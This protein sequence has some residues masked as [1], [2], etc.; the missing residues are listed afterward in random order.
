MNIRKT[1]GGLLLS[2]ILFTVVVAA[3]KTNFSG[4][5]VM[6]QAEGIPAD[7]KQNMK[8]TQDGDKVEIET[9]LFQGDN[10]QTVPD[11]YTLDGKETQYHTRLASGEETQAKRIAKW[12]ADGNGF[13]ARDVAVFDMA[14]GKVTI[15]TVRKWL[16]AA[17][18]KSLVIE[19]SRSGPQGTVTSKR[20]FT[21]K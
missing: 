14:D 16:A 5:W 9:D 12:N 11:Q 8:V 20:T 19:M 1:S 7:M 18:G 4:R 2:V 6:T 3:D 15:T 13:E 17:D 10:V 21:R